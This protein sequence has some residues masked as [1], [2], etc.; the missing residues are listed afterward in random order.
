MNTYH[1]LEVAKMVYDSSTVREMFP[2]G[3]LV[4]IDRLNGLN[5]PALPY[6]GQFFAYPV[7]ESFSSNKGFVLLARTL[8][9]AFGEK[10]FLREGVKEFSEK[11]GLGID[12]EGIVAE[13]YSGLVYMAT[14]QSADSDSH[15]LVITLLGKLANFDDDEAYD[16][17]EEVIKNAISIAVFNTVQET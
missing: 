2:D 1:P 4:V 7:D 17:A 5:E 15:R 11:Y 13:A 9:Y 10:A 12:V 16:E 3:L 8:Q 6:A 14:I